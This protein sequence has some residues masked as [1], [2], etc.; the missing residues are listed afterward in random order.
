VQRKFDPACLRR[1]A[2]R[3]PTAAAAVHAVFNGGGS[4]VRFVLGG[5]R[6]ETSGA[7][8]PGIWQRD[9]RRE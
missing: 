7:H 2:S 8:Q 9:I 5:R 4:P 3:I 1:V 6:H